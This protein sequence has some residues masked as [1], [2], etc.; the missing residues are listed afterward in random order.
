MSA[1][2]KSLAAYEDT[3]LETPRRASMPRLAV[4]TDECGRTRRRTAWP[5]STVIG[6]ALRAFGV[7]LVGLGFFLGFPVF[8]L[9]IVARYTVGAVWKRRA[10]VGNFVKDAA[11]S[12]AAPF[13][14]VI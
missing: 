14:R 4:V 3:R 6:T 2:V 5:Q 7:C 13:I 9:P 1:S 8:G 12:F 11:L 10:R